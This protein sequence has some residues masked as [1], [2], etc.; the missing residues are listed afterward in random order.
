MANQNIRYVG[1]GMEASDGTI[2]NPEPFFYVDASEVGLDS[3]EEAE[4]VVPSA[5]G[6]TSRAKRGGAY[7]PGGDV[8]YNMDIRSIGWF[9][10]M[11]LTGHGSGT[12]YVVTQEMEADDVTP[13][14]YWIHEI[15]ATTDRYLRPFCARV[16]RDEFEHVFE[17]CAAGSLSFAVSRELIPLT[18]ETN[19][20]RDFKAP[21]GVKSVDTILDNLY[22]EYAMSFQDVS[23][24]V[25]AVDLSPRVM[26]LTG[27]INN[28][29]DSERGV[30]IGS[31]F[32]RRHSSTGRDITMEMEMEFLDLDQKELFWGSAGATEPSAEGSAEFPMEINFDA[33]YNDGD[34]VIKLPKVFFS[35]VST[36]QSGREDITQGVNATALDGEVTL[37]DG[38]TTVK[39]AMYARIR[40]KQDDMS[41]AAPLP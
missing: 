18:M 23:A 31:R 28:N 7:I 17:N 24:T 26:S 1:I 20:A 10:L 14:G 41:A 37:E 22:P 21:G 40:N 11:G 19:S 4:L 3:P 39:T 34:G 36:P 6:M 30:T 8:V 32:P 2:T 9:L 16:G 5:L 33:P 15:W 25:N 35:S 13:T 27:N 38:T 29:L 12:G